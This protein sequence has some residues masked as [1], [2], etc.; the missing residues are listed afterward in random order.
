MNTYLSKLI[1]F[2]LKTGLAG[3]K[4]AESKRPLSRLKDIFR[5][6]RHD[7]PL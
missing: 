1:T 3:K 7:R 4:D 2:D 6:E 5:P